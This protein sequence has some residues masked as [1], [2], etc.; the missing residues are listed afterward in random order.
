MSTPGPRPIT[1]D[2]EFLAAILAEL[3]AI[4][5]LLADGLPAKPAP[6]ANYDTVELREPKRARAKAKEG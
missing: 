4:R 3:Q 6:P 1:N 5:A 2:Q